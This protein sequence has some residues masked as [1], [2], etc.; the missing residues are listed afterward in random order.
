MAVV[1]QAH[2]LAIDHQSLHG[3]GK[4]GLHNPR[5]A[6]GPVQ[7]VAGPEAHSLA[8]L[9][10]DDAVA[11]ILE[12]VNPLG[13]GRHLDG[14]GRQTGSDEARRRTPGGTHTP[15]SLPDLIHSGR[16]G[17]HRSRTACWVGN[18]ALVPQR[19]QLGNLSFR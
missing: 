2:G 15:L 4:D 10:G 3:K 17:S 11:V 7:A 18:P 8:I 9:A 14:Q 12:F 1:A 6:H 16:F 5:K 13:A 19:D